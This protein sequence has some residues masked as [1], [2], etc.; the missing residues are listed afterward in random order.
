MNCEQARNGLLPAN[1][2]GLEETESRALENHLT[3]CE[4]CKTIDSEVSNAL[5][6]L[7]APSMKAPEAAW[8]KIKSRIHED[9]ARKPSAPALKIAVS[10]TYCKGQLERAE[11]VFCGSCLAPHHP[12]CFEEYGRCSNLGCAETRTVKPLEATGQRYPMPAI[13]AKASEAKPRRRA[14]LVAALFLG[15]GT[16]FGVAAMVGDPQKSNSVDVANAV[17]LARPLLKK[18][19]TQYR[20]VLDA[21]VSELTVDRDGDPWFGLNTWGTKGLGSFKSSFKEA[22]A[23]KREGKDDLVIESGMLTVHGDDGLLIA[24]ALDTD[25]SSYAVINGQVQSVP[26]SSSTQKP[27]VLDAKIFQLPDGETFLDQDKYGRIYARALNQQ[28]VVY[29]P[30]AAGRYPKSLV[31]A[32]AGLSF[33]NSSEALLFWNDRAGTLKSRLDPSLQTKMTE[34]FHLKDGGLFFLYKD[35]GNHYSG[36]FRAD[37]TYSAGVQAVVAGKSGHASVLALL[38]SKRAVLIKELDST[39]SSFGKIKLAVDE[40]K[41]WVLN[42]AELT[43][44]SPN[45]V[46]SILKFDQALKNNVLF[47]AP[48]DGVFIVQDNQRLDHITVDADSVTVAKA[49]VTIADTKD[50]FSGAKGLLWHPLTVRGLNQCN[51]QGQNRE[52]LGREALPKISIGE[53]LLAVKKN[54][55][56]TWDGTWETQLLPGVGE[57]S[58]ILHDQQSKRLVI[59]SPSKDPGSLRLTLFNLTPGTGVKKLAGVVDWSVLIPFPAKADAL[60]SSFVAGGKLWIQENDSILKAISLPPRTH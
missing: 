54:A 58:H 39:M 49:G 9:I 51:W 20:Q 57:N 31:E 35:G 8:D 26:P 28:I 2:D 53:T 16:M 12:G 6:L 38:A 42:G 27:S 47:P 41:L 23:R 13:Q 14:K 45:K 59:L 55:L 60:R 40:D 32:T 15:A 34:G 30:W 46:Q 22:F 29:D 5:S 50:L 33:R 10:C 17:P 25:E 43:C 18:P 1:F 48:Y 24:Q 7:E 52:Q 56:V 44:L 4:A 36:R 11:S 37:G 3:S 21:R 19:R